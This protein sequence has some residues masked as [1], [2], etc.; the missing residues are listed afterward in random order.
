MNDKVTLIE[1]AKDMGGVEFSTLY[2]VS[3]LDPA[4][5][6]VTV[7]CPGE[8]KLS[9]AC[10]NA[11]VPIVIVPLP[12]LFSTSF[13]VGKAD[14]RLPNLLAWIWD[15]IAVLVVANRLRRY[16]SQNATNL[17]VTK[18][19]YAHLCGSLAARKA[20]VKCI[21]HVQDFISERWGG[22]YRRI[23]GLFARILAD[24]I[25]VDGTP[26]AGQLPGDVQN[27]VSVIFNGV[28]VN[29]FKP[30]L[31]SSQIRY[32]FSLASDD[33]VIGNVAR[34]TP[35]KGQHFI[36]DAFAG[37]AD[38]YPRLRLLFVG[39]STFDDDRYEKYL[40]SKTEE[41][42]LNDKV[43]FTGF[44]SDLPEV[45]ASMDIFAYSSVEK[46]TSP[47]ALISAMAC[48]L[49]IVAFDIAGIREVLNGAGLLV[50]VANADEMAFAL[51]SVIADEDLWI[52]LGRLSRAKAMSSF[53][54][55]TVC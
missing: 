22:L 10:R 8:G 5:W 23:F 29:E 18:G 24:H 54:L 37:L 12:R 51:E 28:D 11:G 25:V 1:S 9:S 21:W 50:P 32:E 7:V 39:A 14:M 16:I 3:H 41:L 19:I 48:G 17:V 49:P 53:R 46:D 55:R 31:D 44:R 43:I 38:R 40:R 27:R 26:I 42:G 4:L 20:G 15:C 30:D 36:L 34:I 35:W 2:L 6:T 33:I 45:L 47:L 13:R 52:K